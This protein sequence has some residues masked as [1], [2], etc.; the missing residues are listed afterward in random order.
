MNDNFFTL[1]IAWT[2]I[3]LHCPSHERQ[4]FTSSIT[5]T[6][7]FYIVHSMKDDFF[8]LSIPWTTIFLHCPSHERQFF[9]SSIAWRTIFL[10]CPYHERQFFYIV[11]HM[12]DNFLHRPYHE[13]RFF[14]SFMTWTP[15]YT[16]T[17]LNNNFIIAQSMNE[18]L[19]QW[20][21]R[22]W[23]WTYMLIL[24]LYQWVS[25]TYR[26]WW[27]EWNTCYTG[28]GKPPEDDEKA[29]DTAF[30]APN[31]GFEIPYLAVWCRARYLSVTEASCDRR[32]P[33]GPDCSIDPIVA[34][35]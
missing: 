15:S 32:M 19:R 13:R 34:R 17:W 24:C 1:S 4:F 31:T 22:W 10:H 20:C 18:F 6:T 5:W 7:I 29:D 3:F 21:A 26:H 14:T 23:Q 9:T 8:T 35:N 27:H 2:T 33:A 28:P 25:V 30:Q 12:N 16:S 11:H